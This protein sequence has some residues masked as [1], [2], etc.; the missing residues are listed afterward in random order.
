MRSCGAENRHRGH[1]PI[2]ASSHAPARIPGI[3]DPS[4]PVADSSGYAPSSACTTPSARSWYVMWVGD[5]PIIGSQRASR[6]GR[7]LLIDAAAARRRSSFHSTAP[8]VAACCA[9]RRIA[10]RLAS[11][12]ERRLR[13]N[14]TIAASAMR[15]GADISTRPSG[16]LMRRYMFLMGLRT[17]CTSRPSI[18]TANHC[19]ACREHSRLPAGSPAIRR[20]AASCTS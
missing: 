1:A 17:T 19:E 3:S 10:F 13:T 20:P 4:A 2:D 5:L 12:H 14:E 15:T 8:V 18:I 9:C 6:A 7:A 16:G 11:I